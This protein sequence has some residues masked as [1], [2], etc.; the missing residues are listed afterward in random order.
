MLKKWGEA[1]LA[2]VCVLAIVFAA[3]YTR[4]DDLRRLA[5]QNAA[6]SQDETLNEALEERRFQPPVAQGAA[7][8]LSGAARTEAGLWRFSPYVFFPAAPGQSVVAMGGGTVLAAEGGY[9]SIDHGGG[10]ETRYRLLQSLRVREGQSV[11]AGQ[12]IGAAGSGGVQVCALQNGA[13]IDP[14]ELAQ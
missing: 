11:A 13:Y 5:A 12:A 8:K 1:V 6:A 4:Q 10:V 2:A 14:G 3:L 9:V 7:S